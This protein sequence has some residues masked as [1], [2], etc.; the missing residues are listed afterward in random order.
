VKKALETGDFDGSL[1]DLL[2]AEEGGKARKGV[3]SAI[4]GRM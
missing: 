1:A 2:A 3:I 4:T